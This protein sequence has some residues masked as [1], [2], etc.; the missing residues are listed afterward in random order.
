HLVD[1][2]ECHHVRFD[3]RPVTI[4]VRFPRTPRDLKNALLLAIDW[5]GGEL[6]VSPEETAFFSEKLWQLMT[7]CEERR[8]AGEG[9]TC[10]WDFIDAEG[11]SLAYQKLFANAITRSLVAAKAERASTRTIGNIFIQILIDVLDPSVST[12]DRVLDGPTNEVWIEP[13]LTYLRS[14]GV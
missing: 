14:R 9:K 1:T 10:W 12:A 2:T 8:L 11:R 3:K 7:S 5:L 4:P 6:E 13:W